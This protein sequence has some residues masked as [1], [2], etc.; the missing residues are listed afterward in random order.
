[1]NQFISTA[2]PYVNAS[3]HIGF[4]LEL[5]ITDVLARHS[6]LRRHET[7]FVSGTDENSLKNVLAA[8][9]A[10]CDVKDFVAAHAA[11]FKA[12]TEPLDLS[13]D[14]FIRTSVDCRHAP[15]VE[16]LWRAVEAAGDIY[17][18][19][20][21]GLYCVGCEQFYRE[22]ELVDGRCPE[23]G[24]EPERVA[25]SNYFFRLS[26]YQNALVE[27]IQSGRLR[28]EPATR[29]NE[30][31]SFLARP[32]EDLSISRSVERAHGWGIEVPGDPTQIV[33]V[34]FDAL[35]NYISAYG[36]RRWRDADKISHVIGKGVSRFHAVYWPA[37]LLSAGRRLPDEILVHGY[38]TT[39]G[40]KIS[41][42]AGRSIDV[43]GAAAACGTDALR[44]YLIRHV[45]SHRD[46]DF[47]TA[48]LEHAYTHELANQLGNLVSRLVTLTHEHCIRDAAS[49]AHD[50]LQR[51]V[52]AHLDAFAVH[53]ALAE[54]WHE[55]E[56]VNAYISQQQPWRLAK[57]GQ[58][59]AL[60]DVLGT[61]LRRV[62]AIA[63]V[64]APFLP[65][66]S[67]RIHARLDSGPGEPLFP[68][69]R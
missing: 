65:R 32:L 12:L 27:L 28:I 68:K 56:D 25:E 22:P 16:S 51:R 4:A 69:S 43:T 52:S 31:L 17:R 33:Y 42:S 26:R 8:E 3:P 39:D 44:Y 21:T 1:M 9:R 13:T 18:A 54:I 2:I 23:H 40:D 46:G 37:I 36:A 57:A 66:T 67:Q 41:K 48:R 61:A 50:D 64:L 63:Y 55:V 35:V 49:A 6:R 45:G 10:G 34:W 14:D 20:Y 29:R 5:V 47:S 19:D 59:T 15:E 30:M 58:T 7:F 38:V 24:T 53:R 11:E 62:R 60:H